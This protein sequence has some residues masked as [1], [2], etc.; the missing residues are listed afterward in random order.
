MDRYEVKLDG[1]NVV[2]N[3]GKLLSG[4]P[5]GTDHFLTA[6]KGPGCIGKA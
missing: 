3:T 6:P 2:V 1:G 4:P 5:R